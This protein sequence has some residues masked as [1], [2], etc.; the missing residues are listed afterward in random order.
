MTDIFKEIRKTRLFGLSA[1]DLFLTVIGTF[2]LHFVLWTYPL[3]MKDKNERTYTQYFASFT[4]LFI[5]FVGL[6]VILHRI[7][8]IKSA[9]SGYLGLNDRVTV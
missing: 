3:D 7:F 5:T 6:G 4:L 8:G 1:I 2:I 9:L